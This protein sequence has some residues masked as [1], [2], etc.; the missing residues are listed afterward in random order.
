MS[1]LLDVP[2]FPFPVTASHPGV[3]RR[4]QQSAAVIATAPAQTDFYINPGG[5]DS[6]DAETTLT[7]AT[8]LGLPPA[9]DFQFSCRVSVDFRSQYDAGVLMLWADERHWAKFCFELSPSSSPMIVSVVTRGVSDDANAFVVDDRT[10]WLRVSR[11]DRSYAYHASTDGTTW[12]LVRVFRL[13]DEIAD[14]RIGL[15]A[16]SPSGDGC[17]VT[18]D[19]I[20]FTSQRLTEL[21]DGS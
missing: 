12:Q 9:G 13:D 2:Q 10:V 3:W 6:T 16:Q 15:E 11:I 1:E 20:S 8:L 21:R 17:T 18:F 5:A 14:H 4:D 7:G 19:H